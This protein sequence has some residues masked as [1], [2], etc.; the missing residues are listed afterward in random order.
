MQVLLRRG[1]VLA[2]VHL[3]SAMPTLPHW[4]CPS[5]KEIRSKEMANVAVTN[6]REMGMMQ[7]EP[8]I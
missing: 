5:H 6:E 4:R 1:F 8:V 7:L 3:G 2:V